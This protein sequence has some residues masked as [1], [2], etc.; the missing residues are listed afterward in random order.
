ML[1]KNSTFFALQHLQ[2]RGR[3]VQFGLGAGLQYSATPTPTI[4]HEDEHEHEDDFD[5][6][7]EGGFVIWTYPGLKPRAESCCPF[8]TCEPSALG[9][10]ISLARACSRRSRSFSL[11]RCLK[12]KPGPPLGF[13]DPVLDQASGSHIVVPVADIMGRTQ[14]LC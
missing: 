12:Q 8:G 11:L 14:K 6:P 7:C 10:Y 3:G 4:E 9:A 2:P 13:I 5:V 1:R